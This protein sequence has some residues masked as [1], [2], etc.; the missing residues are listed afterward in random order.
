LAATNANGAWA[1]FCQFIPVRGDVCS[2]VVAYDVGSN[3]LNIGSI[4]AP[5]VR[6]SKYINFAEIA[7]VRFTAKSNGIH[8]TQITAW[9]SW[10]FHDMR[11]RVNEVEVFTGEFPESR[12][13]TY[14]NSFMLN[15]GQ[16]IDLI[17]SRVNDVFSSRLNGVYLQGE[18]V[19]L[20]ETASA[21]VTFFPAPGLFTNSVSVFL[22][23]NHSNGVIHFTTDGSSP[24][25]SSP[26]YSNAL[27]LT[28]SA[29]VRAAVF[30]GSTPVSQVYTASYARVYAVNDGIPVSWR[31]QYFG[32]GYLTDSRVSANADPDGDLSTNWEEFLAGTNPLDPTSGFKATVTA[33]PMLH[34]GSV[35][36]RSYRVRRRDHVNSAPIALATI[37]ATNTITTY[38]D[39]S[40]TASTGIYMIE[41]LP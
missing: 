8:Q 24:S 13:L 6:L 32:P 41:L 10:P 19:A 40:V 9:S 35:A 36:G 20:N 2:A 39:T 4:G 12:M 16:T 38:V 7:V 17:G 22:F 33:V 11:V 18:V 27:T 5:A 25:S 34:F 23:N 28:A 3:V 21:D 26:A 1:A 15:A 30:S 31:E 37:T 14:S 29:D